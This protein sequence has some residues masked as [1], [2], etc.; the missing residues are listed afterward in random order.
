VTRLADTVCVI[1]GASSGIGEATAR[2]LARAG[3]TVV[4]AARREELLQKLAAEIRERGGEASWL[5]TDVT[6]QEDL[7]ALRDHALSEH[8]HCD[9]LINNAGIPGGGALADLSIERIRAVTETNYLSVVIA[10]RVFLD[11]LLTSRGHVVNVASLAG[12]FAFPGASV[13]SASK[14]AVVAFSGSLQGDPTLKGLK[15]TAVCPGFVDTP[16]F[17]HE[18]PPGFVT[19]T[20]EQVA[21]RIARVIR[22]DEIGT[23]SIPAWP[24]PLSAVQVLAPPVY[25][26]VA[27]L[28]ARRYRPRIHSD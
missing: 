15:V 3:A 14:H 2:L 20:S 24:G 25:R 4:L 1:T 5:R 23:V 16:G 27:G 8:G 17:P 9:V 12:R 10:T 21:T 22:R 18:H 28:G 7:E 6:R 19:I 11:T 26:F 13:Y